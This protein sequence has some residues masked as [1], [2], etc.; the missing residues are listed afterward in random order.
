MGLRL[1]TVVLGL[2]ASTGFF[3]NPARVARSADPV[4]SGPRVGQKP[5]PYS[6]LVATGPE[7]GQQTCYVCEAGDKPGVIV[8]AR[9]LT[10][11]LSD[12]LAKCDTEMAARPKDSMRAWLTV[13][14]EKTVALDDLAKW[15][16]EAGIKTVPTG[17]FDDLTGPPSYRIAADAEVT[18][19]LFFNK[20]VVENYAF[21]VGDL[22]EAAVKEIATAVHALGEKK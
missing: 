10:A 20:K 21:R 16:K 15:S 9:S 13:L 14:G 4:G 18:V 22:N 6:F 8:F 2:I 1:G 7:R 19:L 11:P 5:G 3:A 17:V 12:L